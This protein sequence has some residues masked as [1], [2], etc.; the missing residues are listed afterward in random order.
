MPVRRLNWDRMESVAKLES[1]PT[2]GY[3]APCREIARIVTNGC[4]SAADGTSGF[5]GQALRTNC[6]FVMGRLIRHKPTGAFLD[7]NG[8][9]TKDRDQAQNFADI[10][11]LIEV[12]R[13]LKLTDIEEVMQMEAAPSS[14]YDIALPLS[15]PA[16]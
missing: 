1:A 10:I 3:F 8:G 2:A 11:S 4:R 14:A 9:W 6:A 12:Q 15:N 5:A 7:R 16:T 13:R